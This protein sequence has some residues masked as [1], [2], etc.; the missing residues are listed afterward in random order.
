MD[1]M[2]K[3]QNLMQFSLLW[4]GLCYRLDKFFNLIFYYHENKGEYQFFN[5]R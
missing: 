1:C 2:K 5:E 4:H 3:N